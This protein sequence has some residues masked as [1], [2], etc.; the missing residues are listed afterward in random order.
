MKV[1][2]NTELIEKRAKWGRRIAPLTML[3]LIGGLITNFLSINQPEYFRPT[4]ILLALGF[5]SAIL[6]SNLVNKWVREP[7][8]DQVL[9][10][11]LKKFG[12][13]YWLF[14]YTSPVPHAL[15]AP[16]G[17]YTIAV[18]PQDGQIRVDG[19]RFS[20]KFTWQRLFRFLADES[21]GAPIA[22]AESQA[23][24]LHK[25]LTKRLTDEEIPEI[26]PLVLFTNKNVN[27]SVNNP[28]IP[29][30]RTSELKSFL[31][32]QGKNRKISADQRKQ[33]AGILSGE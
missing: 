20:R 21:L 1:N 28:A 14:N 32:E 30:M 26:I 22:E 27:L 23:R 15:L 10:Q 33:L 6:S 31:R 5:T 11:L 8:A 25:S 18:K 4:I 24:K 16:N 7:R 13:D 12:N 2:T 29:V 19:Q 9:T 3:F 17:L